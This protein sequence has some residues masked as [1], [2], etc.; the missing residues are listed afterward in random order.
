MSDFSSIH[1]PAALRPHRL[2]S[3]LDLVVLTLVVLVVAFA[4]SAIGPTTHAT[5]SLGTVLKQDAR[6]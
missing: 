5:V 6:R 4:A 1:A 3:G 2:R